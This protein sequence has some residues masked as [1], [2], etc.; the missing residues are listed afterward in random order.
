VGAL[1]EP[2]NEDGL[3]AAL[4]DAAAEKRTLAVSS[5]GTKVGLG[6]PVDAQARLSVARLS[7]ISYYAPGELVMEAGAATPVAEIEVVL[8]ENGQQM[9]F[10][11]PDLGPLYGQPPAAATIGGVINCNLS[12]SRRP[13]AGAARD[14]ILGIR[15]ISGRGEVFT[16]GGRVVKNVTGYDMSK[17]LA[18]S[19][20]TLA[21]L[22]VVTFKVLS[23]AKA[24]RTVLLFGET[25]ADAS[26]TM[27]RAVDGPWDISAA[28]YLPQKVAVRS[29]VAYVAAAAA[30][31]TALRLEGSREGVIARTLAL[32]MALAPSDET[33]ELHATRSR[34]F[35]AETASGVLFPAPGVGVDML[36][37]LS[38]PPAQGV[39][40]GIMIQ[41]ALGGDVAFDWAGG[42][43]WCAP[44]PVI[45][46][47]AVDAGAEE[48]RRI[49]A[50]H[51]GHATLIRAP[52]DV[53][54]RVPVFQPEEAEL[55]ALTRRV[56]ENFDPQGILNPGRMFEGV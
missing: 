53:R 55:A 3:R 16:S 31:V 4:A 33:E 5:G 41:K 52:D 47:A 56:K 42:L 39:A 32:R 45:S 51:G 8:A 17:L 26:A 6:R 35:W 43:V 34:A 37:R 40:A 1:I 18:G 49:V 29:S 21:V 25:P 30:P 9:A 22:S 24:I 10:E 36:W 2:E 7:G 14:H 48:L 15:A 11:P 27:G 50:K 13:F 12:G 38:L 20:G 46:P 54:G 44:A 28:A 19:H 23:R